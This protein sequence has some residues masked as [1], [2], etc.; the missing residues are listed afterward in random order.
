MKKKT[1]LSTH[2]KVLDELTHKNKL[3]KT[4]LTKEQ[5][6]AVRGAVISDILNQIKDDNPSISKMASDASFRIVH[7]AQMILGNN[8]VV[9]E[10]VEE[11]NEDDK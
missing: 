8:E 5:E 7:L 3:E 4:L 9:K 6:D 11:S 2:K 10:I 1:K